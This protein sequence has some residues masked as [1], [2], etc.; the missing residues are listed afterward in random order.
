M[1]SLVEAAVLPIASRLD[2]AVQGPPITCMTIPT[3]H[4]H[5][6]NGQD[7]FMGRRE[8][9]DELRGHVEE[10]HEILNMPSSKAGF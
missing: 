1:I 6:G 7:R 8:D 2:Q 10:D 4:R 5:G 9:D 3:S